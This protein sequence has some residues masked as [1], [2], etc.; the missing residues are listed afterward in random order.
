MRFVLFLL[1]LALGIAG[2]LAYTV[3]AAPTP[4]PMSEP[5]PAD[6]QITVM[7]GE[8][9]LTEVIRRAAVETPGVKVSPDLRVELRDDT[10]IVHAKVDVLGQPTEGTAVLRPVLRQERLR[11]DV[12]ETNLGAL[13]MPA[14]EQVLERAIDARMQS[15]LAGVPVAVTGVTVD[16]AHG[17]TVTCRVNVDRLEPRAAR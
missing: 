16:R 8:R 7:L 10:M 15:L 1:G 9:F 13:P 4:P 12:V 5:L 11:M 6:P 14:M 17:L 2:T 3:F